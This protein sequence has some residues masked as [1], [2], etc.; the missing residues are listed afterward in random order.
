MIP[1]RLAAE[2]AIDQD[3]CT[4]VSC[5]GCVDRPHQAG[6]AMSVLC[7][8]PSIQPGT[9]L[10]AL[11][12]A[13]SGLCRMSSPECLRHVLTSACRIMTHAVWQGKVKDAMGH[14]NAHPAG[15]STQSPRL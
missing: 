2:Q 6:V 3:I 5:F 14:K 8:A 7:P 4:G 1:A 11:R 9:R 10:Q 13:C 12:K 15:T